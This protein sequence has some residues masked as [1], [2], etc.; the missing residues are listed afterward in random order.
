MAPTGRARA[1]HTARPSPPAVDPALWFTTTATRIGTSTGTETETAAARC[2]Q[3]RG[4]RGRRPRPAPAPGRAPWPCRWPAP[5]P[6]AR[7][8][9]SAFAYPTTF[10]RPGWRHAFEADPPVQDRKHLQRFGGRPYGF[11]TRWHGL[12]RTRDRERRTRW[13]Q[14]TPARRPVRRQG[15]PGRAERWPSAGETASSQRSA[16]AESR[17]GIQLF[18]TSSHETAPYPRP[19]PGRLPADRGDTSARWDPGSFGGIPGG[20]PGR[21]GMGA[22]VAR[23]PTSSHEILPAGGFGLDGRLPAVPP[24]W[25]EKRRTR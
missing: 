18:P 9:P 24:T 1:H 17:H 21:P 8:N 7:P 11:G 22:K 13:A 14:G 4:R 25:W 19:P 2:I 5:N 16:P 23:F 15:G 3:G 20:A 6:S 10:G 12:P